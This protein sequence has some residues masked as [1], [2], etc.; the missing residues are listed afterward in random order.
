MLILLR[1]LLIAQFAWAF[2]LSRK[3]V[4]YTGMKRVLN[5]SS[6]NPHR[7]GV[8]EWASPLAGAIFVSLKAIIR[9]Y[10]IMSTTNTGYFKQNNA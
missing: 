1:L 9:L 2:P 7:D 5:S 3:R 6:K 8:F 4:R 10:R